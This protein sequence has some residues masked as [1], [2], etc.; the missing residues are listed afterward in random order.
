MTTTD[1]NEE[2]IFENW[3]KLTLARNKIIQVNEKL[4][5]EPEIFGTVIKE[6]DNSIK[7][8]KEVKVFLIE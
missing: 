1:I 2:E 6:L 7:L 5:L 3:K 8:M 4:K